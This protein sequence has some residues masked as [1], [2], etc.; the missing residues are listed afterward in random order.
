MPDPSSTVEEHTALDYLVPLKRTQE[1]TMGQTVVHAA[2][3]AERA[4]PAV[5]LLETRRADLVMLCESR[6]RW[7]GIHFHTECLGRAGASPRITG[8][9]RV[10]VP[11]ERLEEARRLLAAMDDEVI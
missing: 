1:E 10:C 11:A 6:L 5:P 4:R 3:G 7:A 8:P 2:G 9:L